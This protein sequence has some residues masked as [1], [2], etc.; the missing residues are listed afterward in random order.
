[1][2]L[3][4]WNDVNRFP[5]LPSLLDNFFN[6]DISDFLG[7]WEGTVPSVNVSE[8][9]DDYRIEM[10]APG[11]VKEN[12]DVK[13]ENELL[14]I[15]GNQQ[16]QKEDHQNKYHRREFSYQSF[17][18]SFHLPEGIDIERIEATYKEGILS[19]RL[20]KKEEIKKRQ[21]VKSIS[22]S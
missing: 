11:M 22:I 9:S 20:P 19:V 16:E 5:K 3:I 13:I 21:E 10:A 12:L 4:K 18:R 2:S 1:M 8:T 14:V 7:N 15:T 6:S 17:Q